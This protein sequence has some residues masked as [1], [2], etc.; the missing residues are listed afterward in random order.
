MQTL[1][2]GLLQDAVDLQVGHQVCRAGQF[3][4]VGGTGRTAGAHSTPTA[5]APICM[6]WTADAAAALTVG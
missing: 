3:R 6:F 5:A 1:E 2:V 4:R